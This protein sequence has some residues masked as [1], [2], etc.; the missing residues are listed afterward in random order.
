MRYTTFC[1]LM[2]ISQRYPPLVSRKINNTL[3]R[4]LI[5]LP[6]YDENDWQT[7]ASYHTPFEAYCRRELP[8]KIRTQCEIAVEK[9]AQQLGQ[10][11]TSE[12][13]SI[14]LDCL[15][16]VV[17][18]FRQEHRLDSC[19]T[20]ESVR[21][22]NA[23]HTS[24]LDP[25]AST[26]SRGEH[27]LDVS[28]SLR[29]N[30]LQNLQIAIPDYERY[31]PAVENH[32]NTSIGLP[33]GSMNPS[34]TSFYLKDLDSMSQT[35]AVDHQGCEA[36]RD[37]LCLPSLPNELLGP[38]A[39]QLNTDITHRPS[40]ISLSGSNPWREDDRDMA[41]QDLRFEDDPH[42]H[43]SAAFPDIQTTPETAPQIIESA[44]PGHQNLE[45]YSDVKGV[46]EDD[47]NRAFGG[48]HKC[49]W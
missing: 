23:A 25:A 16:T 15:D 5:K 7:S 14:V 49:R 2:M 21:T 44:S 6:V 8:R 40:M 19:R 3:Y 36:P 41:G 48:I 28:P 39:G 20:S 27:S 46:L 45:N 13:E 34:P 26:T 22:N 31:A 42:E 43:L 35:S 37:M 1:S 18:S 9:M 30:N 17:S 38:Y 24:T 11:L 29:L 12:I 33:L 32:F 47:L 4:P 10:T